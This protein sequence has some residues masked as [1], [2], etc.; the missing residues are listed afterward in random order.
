MKPRWSP[1]G[2]QIVFYSD[3][4]FI[5][6]IRNVDSVTS[7]TPFLV[8][9]GINPSFM[10]D[11][12]QIMFNDEYEDVLSIFVIDTVTT[13]AEPQL[14]SDGSYSNMQVLSHDGR[15]ACVLCFC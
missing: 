8:W 3:K 1:D 13:G 7:T 10:P 14:V 6:L 11:G 5:Y 2:K 15:Q 12:D 9:D 4:G